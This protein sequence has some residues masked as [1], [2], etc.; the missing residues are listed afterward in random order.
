MSSQVQLSEDAVRKLSQIIFAC[1]LPGKSTLKLFDPTTGKLEDYQLSKLSADSGS[2]QSETEADFNNVL[3]SLKVAVLEDQFRLNLPHTP[4]STLS[5]PP[6]YSQ[7]S[8][9]MVMSPVPHPS[10]DSDNSLQ[11]GQHKPLFLDFYGQEAPRAPLLRQVPL[12]SS[13][14]DT[15]TFTD[16]SFQLNLADIGSSGSS[17][18]APTAPLLQYTSAHS[19]PIFIP[20]WGSFKDPLRPSG[21]GLSG[22]LNDDGTS[23]DGLGALPADPPSPSDEA[24]AR[25]ALRAARA[26]APAPTPALYAPAV[27]KQTMR[28]DD[29]DFSASRA[30]VLVNASTPVSF[31]ART[32]VPPAAPARR[33]VRRLP[34]RPEPKNAAGPGKEGAARRSEAGHGRL[35]ALALGAAPQ[36]PGRPSGE[37][38]RFWA[39]WMTPASEREGDRRPAWRP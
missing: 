12:F 30:P 10:A 1:V 25:R 2:G 39:H 7:A 11:L 14:F 27:H 38:L 29:D 32:T 31:T 16:E 20:S 18:F 26:A 23:F 21:L 4:K 36:T 5:R 8:D 34:T 22:L 9:T 19:S 17:F 35:A 24:R 28:A 3:E 33:A 37:E 6:P 15:P 13:G